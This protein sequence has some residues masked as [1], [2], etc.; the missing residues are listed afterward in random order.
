MADDFSADTSTT[1]VVLVGGSVTGEI[2]PATDTDWF[3]VQMEAGRF[4]QIELV[5]EA[6][7]TMPGL[8]D[9]LIEGVYDPSG[10]YI[11]NTDNDDSDG[12]L[13]SKLLFEA[14]ETGTYYISAASYSTISP[15]TTL[16][17][18]YRLS[19][20]TVDITDDFPAS[21]DTTG[22]LTLES[23]TFGN[24]QPLAANSAPDED[25][26]AIELKAGTTY[27]FRSGAWLAEIAA[28]YDETGAPLSLT[29]QEFDN[30]TVGVFTAPEDGTYYVSVGGSEYYTYFGEGNYALTAQELF[31]HSADEIA[32]LPEGHPENVWL[33]RDTWKVAVEGDAQSELFVGRSED[34]TISGAG[35]SDTILGNVGDDFLIG[36]NA[37]PVD[38]T[39]AEM[40]AVYGMYNFLLGRS[41]TTSELAN[42]VSLVGGSG[43]RLEVLASQILESSEFL[44][45][46]GEMTNEELI[47]FYYVQLRG[48]VVDSDPGRQ[49]WL[50]LLTAQSTYYDAGRIARA[51][52]MSPEYSR[53]HSEGAVVEIL[54]TQINGWADEVFGAYRGL[55]GRDPDPRG[56]DNWYDRMAQ[57]GDLGD[58]AQKFLRSPEF[59]KANTGLS[60]RDFA[61][62]VLGNLELPTGSGALDAAEALLS[63]GMSRADFTAVQILMSDDSGVTDWIRARGPDD[64]LVGGPG[65]DLLFG[66]ELSDRF[67]F[68]PGL[69]GTDRVLDLEPWDIID[70]TAFGFADTD[71]ALA[72]FSQE[73]T[74]AVFEDQ[75]ITVR[76][77]NTDLAMIG[78]EMLLV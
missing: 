19:V 47:D 21:P 74:V 38:W 59:Q 48:D 36:D 62:L 6:T 25:W 57:G 28:V 14:T 11:E 73:G 20:S 65:S 18:G 63:G 22:V 56:F 17:G 27:S 46:H 64:V 70:L 35:G 16:T 23:A 41:P 42:G 76:F 39:L 45:L 50:D 4:Y 24:I 7:A 54:S 8:S 52:V 69:L 5:G 75:G 30:Q 55:L 61:A 31:E 67:V 1:G 53:A 10:Q 60:D 72:A 51:F 3:A 66:G 68:E 71:A 15:Y 44:D 29:D 78:E 58:L 43:Y 40:V 2:D 32:A 37:L 33:L 12:T 9:T 77:A 26:F 13:F 49:V 34:E